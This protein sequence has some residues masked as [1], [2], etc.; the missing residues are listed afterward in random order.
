MQHYAAF[1]QGLHCLQKYMFVV[2]QYTK[3]LSTPLPVI[4]A[5]ELLAAQA[6]MRAHK[7]FIFVYYVVE[8]WLL[9]SS[10]EYVSLD[11]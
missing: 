4:T 10:N 8:P 5:Q 3:G 1:Y 2:F 7:S 11:I 9:C 6:I